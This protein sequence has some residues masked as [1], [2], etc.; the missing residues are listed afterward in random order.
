ME[1][2]VAIVTGGASGIGKAIADRLADRGYTVVV[3]DIN[4]EKGR[5]LEKVSNKVK[6][7]YVFKYCNVGEEED[8]RRVVEE[9]EREYGGISVLVN[10]AGII[11]R[12][13][14]EEIKISDW[15]DVFKINTRGA[16][17]FCKY[18]SEVMKKQKSG[19]IINISSVASK[20][21][22]ITSAPGYGPSKAAVNGLT[23]TFARELAPYNITVN[24]VAPHA[25]ET[26]MSAEWSEEMRQKIISEIPLKR[27]G[28]PSEVA[29]VVEFLVSDE[30]GFITGEIIDVNGGFLMD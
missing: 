19:R 28:Q 16:F 14:G 24:A 29:A 13:K 27:L 20:M 30:A 9:V 5:A 2:K 17:I 4:E 3:C 11:R 8:I 10:N 26:E 7:T 1:G 6:G 12:R 21:G 15:D 22:D 25:I 23:K 18:V